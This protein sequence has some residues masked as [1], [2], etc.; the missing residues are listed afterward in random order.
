METEI[1]F[2]KRLYPG[3]LSNPTQINMVIKSRI[4]ERL[5][6]LES[7]SIGEKPET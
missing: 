4:D 6:Q 2:L 3:H 7:P 5:K 1:D